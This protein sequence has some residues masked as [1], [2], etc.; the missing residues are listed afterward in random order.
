MVCSPNSNDKTIVYTI[1]SIAL[2]ST[3]SHACFYAYFNNVTILEAPTMG[4]TDDVAS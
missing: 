4:G 2:K 3:F 1:D